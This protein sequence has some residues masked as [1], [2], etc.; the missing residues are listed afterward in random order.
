MF[1]FRFKSKY[2]SKQPVNN[3][4]ENKIQK[5]TK[6]ILK[7]SSKGAH[8]NKVKSV[9]KEPRPAWGPNSSLVSDE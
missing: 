1:V 6:S 3:N 8:D 5:N 2:C 4:T 7:S 9:D